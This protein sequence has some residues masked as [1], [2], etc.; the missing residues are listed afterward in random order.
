MHAHLTRLPQ[1]PRTHPSLRRPHGAPLAR[2][3]VPLFGNFRNLGFSFEWHDF[4]CAESLDWA[5]SFHPGSVELCLNL[6][7]RA[8]VSDGR[9]TCDLLPQTL[10][11][12]HQGE[13][14]LRATRQPGERQ[15]FIT[16]EF[17]PEFL[18]KAFGRQVR[19]FASTGGRSGAAG[20]RN[21]VCGSCGA[22][23]HDISGIG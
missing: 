6:A 18:S 22:T 23:G 20:T 5:R 4:V 1:H 21:I 13:P 8:T 11:F 12:Y 14:P 3:G 7:G 19:E 16:V 2:A 9:Q 10:A 17:A 15:Q